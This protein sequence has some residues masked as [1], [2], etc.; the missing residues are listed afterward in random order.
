MTAAALLLCDII[1]PSSFG[2]S[3]PAYADPPPWAPAHGWRA[4]H[5]EEDDQDDEPTVIT[6]P[7]PLIASYPHVEV[8]CSDKPI[9]GTV[10]GGVAGGLIGNQFG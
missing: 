10:I 7:L 9:I 4:K 3:G 1:A 5:H 6:A 2:F 8:T